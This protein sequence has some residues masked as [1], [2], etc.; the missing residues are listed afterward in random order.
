MSG[1]TSPKVADTDDLA[2]ADDAWKVTFHGPR[3]LIQA[4]LVAH[5]DA[6]DWDPEIVIAGS[7]IAE[8]R[9]E[10]WQ[11]E[12]WLSRKPRKKDLSALAAL[13]DGNAPE[14]KVE[15][16]PPTDWVT[17]S[18]AGVE[19]IREG[20][21]HVHTAEF[22]PLD[23]PGVRDFLI[24]ASQAF[25]TG[26]HATTAGCL[27]MLGT[28]K[29]R[30]VVIRNLA[31]IGTGTGL[32][33]FAGLHLWPRARAI[34]SDI[35]AVCGPV[36]VENARANDVSLG[37]GP[38]KL[39]MVIAPG[40]DHPLLATSAPYDLLIANIL[41]GPLVELAPSFAGAVAPGGHILLAGLLTTQEPAVRAAYARAGMRL[42]A[43]MTR[44]DWSILWL[45]RRLM[46]RVRT[47]RV[48]QLPE[49]SRRW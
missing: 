2:G 25:G 9:P 14:A 48:G 26:Q 29:R 15:H 37:D 38:G 44:G 3:T 43:R 30:G 5:E 35:D 42:A 28:M 46:G 27:A 45:R 33:A 8:D 19:P 18:Q 11:L 16:L 21:F 31:D 1:N 23:E 13:F 41:A 22:P 36:V 17:L 32:L 12:A 39:A 4:A 7:E 24:P 10:D 49:W 6:F 47:T 34:A 40:M 20:P